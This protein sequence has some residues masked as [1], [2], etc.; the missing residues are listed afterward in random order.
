MIT[1]AGVQGGAWYRMVC[2]DR[3]GAAGGHEP[4][5]GPRSYRPGQRAVTERSG[6]SRGYRL[7]QRAVTNRS[8]PARSLW[9]RVSAQPRSSA[10]T[11]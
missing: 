7:G 9:L 6:R 5:H 2:L 3:Q 4:V 1:N 10:K 8:R 11:Q